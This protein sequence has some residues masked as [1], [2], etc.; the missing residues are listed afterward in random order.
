MYFLLFAFALSSFQT[1]PE[2]TAPPPPPASATPAAP[3]AEA[4]ATD[5]DDRV[6]CHREHV[7]GSNRRQRVCMTVRQR[8]QAQDQSQDEMRRSTR[9]SGGAESLPSGR[10]GL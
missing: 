8:A 10:S 9:S 7:V 2:P 1:P 6:V 4:R 3:G 5:P